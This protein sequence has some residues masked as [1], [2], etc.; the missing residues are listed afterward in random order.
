MKSK[1]TQERKKMKYLSDI[2][3]FL[4]NIFLLTLAYIFEVRA[5]FW[6]LTSFIYLILSLGLGIR[7][8]Q[9][10]EELRRKEV[11]KNVQQEKKKP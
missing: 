6:V 10:R 7:I 8:R 2:I 5:Y 3:Y 9:L 11:N 4:Y 1:I